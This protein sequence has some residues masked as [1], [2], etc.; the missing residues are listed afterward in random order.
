M[1]DEQ[2]LSRLGEAE[3]VER[4]RATGDPR[5]FEELYR[6]ERRRV[7]A[8]C[9]GILRDP[10]LAEDA[11]HESFLRA[12][13]SFGTLEGPFFGAWIRRIAQRCCLN[14]LRARRNAER[15]APPPPS[16]VEPEAERNAVASEQRSLAR[17]VLSTLR[18]D[19]RQALLLRHVQGLSHREIASHIGCKEEAVRSLLQNGRRNFRLAWGRKHDGMS[20][21]AG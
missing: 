21:R 11:C 15:L 17:E 10:N 12:Y 16:P 18:H 8:T 2:D 5:C 3:L 9:L 4:F 1:S 19:Q 14:T 20:E 6:R 13:Q 7:L